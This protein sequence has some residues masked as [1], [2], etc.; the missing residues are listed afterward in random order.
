MLTCFFKPSEEK[1]CKCEIVK[2]VDRI[3]LDKRGNASCIRDFIIHVEEES[4]P[5]SGIRL[6]IPY[7][8]VLDIQDLT[9]TCWD[10]DYLFNKFHVAGFSVQHLDISSRKG[11]V[12]VDGITD[13]EVYAGIGKNLDIAVDA[14]PPRKQASILS[15][16][17]LSCRLE[18]GKFRHYRI[19][20]KV[21]SV[22]DLLFEGNFFRISLS[23][24]DGSHFRDE[25]RKLDISDLEV[26][27]KKFYKELVQD[28]TKTHYGGVDI[29]LYLDPDARGA[30][31]NSNKELVATHE[32]SATEGERNR[33]KY[34][35]RARLCFPALDVLT[36]DNP[37]W[38]LDG[39]ISDPYQF[40]KIDDRLVEL[41]TTSSVMKERI[42]DL[43]K[44]RK[45]LVISIIIGGIALFFGVY[46][47]YIALIK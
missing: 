24:F 20:F 9:D 39:Y 17:F 32:F 4:I 47:L 5:L 16:D 27:V 36:M 26:P 40:K 3:W 12:N 25:M 29:F 8:N 13:V 33:Q 37:T 46:N 28:G 38:D 31:F 30:Q 34:I 44:D 42:A 18:A 15:I 7:Q 1:E 14:V 2:F 21:T 11:I 35:W 6:F 19:S 41:G 22:L 43:W 23:Y 10:E 45:W